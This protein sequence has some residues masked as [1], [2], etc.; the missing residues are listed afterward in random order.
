MN[1]LQISFIIGYFLYNLW[2]V[3]RGWR[4]CLKREAFKLAPEYWGLGMFVM[5]DT[6]AIGIFWMLLSVVSLVLGDWVLFWF[7]WS[8][9]WAVRSLGESVYW[10]N[11]QFSSRRDMNKPHELPW[12]NVFHDESVWF[13][14]QTVTQCICVAAIVISV[15]LGHM[16]LGS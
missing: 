4:Y 2:S 7:V 13:V 15:W 14:Y 6:F 1:I 11:Q 3:I 5:G 12:N 16:W 8:V 10:F 9:F